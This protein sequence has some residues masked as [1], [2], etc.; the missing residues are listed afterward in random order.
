MERH[1]YKWLC[2]GVSLNYHTVHDFRVDHEEALDDLLT[3]MIAVL[4]QAPIV[5]VQRIAQDGTRIRARAG[6]N[7][8]GERETLEK[9]WEAA[10]AHREAVKPA[11]ADPTLSAQQKAAR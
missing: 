5:S 4:T 7:S 10:R 6:S 2:G 1:P 11:A 9:H 3:Q 8:F